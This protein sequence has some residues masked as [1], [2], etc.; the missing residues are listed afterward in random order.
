MFLF[1]LCFLLF[2]SGDDETGPPCEGVAIRDGRRFI[3]EALGLLQNSKIP[4]DPS[5]AFFLFVFGFFFLSFI[6]MN[7][8]T[9][10][11]F[12][13]KLLKSTT[14][15][16]KKQSGAS[17]DFGPAVKEGAACIDSDDDDD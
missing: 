15:Q 11:R 2:F 7:E 14:K 9:H 4:I 13:F 1:L 3:F 17:A 10:A 16:T 6:L 5:D 12:R 8:L